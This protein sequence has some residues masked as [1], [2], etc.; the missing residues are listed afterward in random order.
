MCPIEVY[1]GGREIEIR[2]DKIPQVSKQVQVGLGGIV[3]ATLQYQTPLKIK[4]AAADEW[5]D[6]HT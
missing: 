2:Y 6:L 4:L 1:R 5:H 3:S